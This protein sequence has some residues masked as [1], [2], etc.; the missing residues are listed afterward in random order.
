VLDAVVV[1]AIALVNGSG[2][3]AVVAEATGQ[4]AL[5]VLTAVTVQKDGAS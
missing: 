4:G 1:G 5:I 3:I 2:G